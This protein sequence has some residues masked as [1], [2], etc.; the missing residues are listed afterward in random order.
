MPQF[1][2]LRAIKCYIMTYS[3]YSYADLTDVRL[4][5]TSSGKTLFWRWDVSETDARSVS[6]WVRRKS[7]ALLNCGL[8][9]SLQIK[10]SS[11][12]YLKIKVSESGL[13]EKINYLICTFCYYVKVRAGQMLWNEKVKIQFIWESL[14]RLVGTGKQPQWLRFLY[15]SQVEVHLPQETRHLNAARVERSNKVLSMSLKT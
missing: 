10:A 12:F 3:I 4:P 1:W 9:S 13:E 15:I 7:A 14:V 5:Q 6:L 2:I 8:K 11:V